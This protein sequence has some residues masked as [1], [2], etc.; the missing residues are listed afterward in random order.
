M[1][2]VTIGELVSQPHRQKPFGK[3]KH[4]N[5]PKT[6]FFK[7]FQ[8]EAFGTKRK[9]VRLPHFINITKHF[10]INYF[11]SI[12]FFSAPFFVHTT[13]TQANRIPKHILRFSYSYRFLDTHFDSHF[14]I[15][16]ISFLSTKWNL[17]G[18]TYSLTY[19]S[20]TIV[21]KKSIINQKKKKKEIN[22]TLNYS[23]TL[24]SANKKIMMLPFVHRIIEIINFSL[25]RWKMKFQFI[26]VL[27]ILK[28][29]DEQL[30]DI[31]ACML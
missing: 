18:N 20:H 4:L 19:V 9:P 26:I 5:K 15:L 24:I 23:F 7:K 21:I 2:G 16:I 12:F 25:A 3:Q 6:M 28:P 13:T 22:W 29:K 11:A 17:K 31:K 8:I 10:T 14:S 1:F 30:T 27:N